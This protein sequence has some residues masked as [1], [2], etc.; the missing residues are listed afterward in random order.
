VNQDGTGLRVETVDLYTGKKVK[1]KVDMVIL[2][3]GME[4]QTDHGEVA[5]RFGI[6]LSPDGFFLER[7]PKLAPVETATDGVFLAGACQSPKDIPDTVAQGSAAAASA[8]ALMDAGTVSLE[9]YT[10]YID[11][12]RCSGCKI[13]VNSCPYNSITTVSYNGHDI[14][15]VNQ[16]TCKGCGTCVASCPAGVAVQRGFMTE[17]IIAEVEGILHSMLPQEV[18]A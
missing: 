2:S 16:V 12:D 1:T 4:P 6:S 11:P 7:H 9:A 14:S 13:C 3:T 8:L 18:G 10:A 15:E 17:Q 5:H